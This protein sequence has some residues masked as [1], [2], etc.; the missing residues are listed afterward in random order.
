MAKCIKIVGD[1]ITSPTWTD[2]YRSTYL[3]GNIQVTG[4]LEVNNLKGWHHPITVSS[5]SS[6]TISP[7]IY[8]D[9]YSYYLPN[10]SQLEDLYLFKITGLTKNGGSDINYYFPTLYVPFFKTFDYDATLRSYLNTFLYFYYMYEGRWNSPHNDTLF[11]HVDNYLDCGAMSSGTFSVAKINCKTPLMQVGQTFLSSGN[12][13][14]N[15]NSMKVDGVFSFKNTTLITG[16]TIPDS[17]TNVILQLNKVIDYNN[18]YEDKKSNYNYISFTEEVYDSCLIVIRGTNL[19][20]KEIILLDL[21]YPDIGI[22]FN[23]RTVNSEL[24]KY[25]PQVYYAYVDR[26]SKNLYIAHNISYT[27]GIIPIKLPKI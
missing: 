16:S 6:V 5:E 17:N 19:D 13:D 27:V 9:W 25:Y 8:N 7:N 15:Y 26:S 4:D 21:M 1:E 23:S 3:R 2:T 24:F 14:S 12:K 20:K 18:A 22:G 11:K 10:D